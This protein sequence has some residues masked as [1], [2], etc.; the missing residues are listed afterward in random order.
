M[1]GEWPVQ[2]P[3]DWLAWVNRPETAEELEALRRSARRGSPYGTQRW[4]RATARRLGIESS[5]RRPGRPSKDE[6]EGRGGE[7]GS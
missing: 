7:N 2:R 4:A 5:L 1:L 3:A 6:K